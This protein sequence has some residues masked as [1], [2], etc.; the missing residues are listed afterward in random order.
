MSLKTKTS[1]TDPSSV[2]DSLAAVTL[3]RALSWEKVVLKLESSLSDCHTWHANC[4][5]VALVQILRLDARWKCCDG[6]RLLAP[7]CGSLFS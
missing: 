3:F 6:S 7:S 4:F 5:A 2:T 1:P